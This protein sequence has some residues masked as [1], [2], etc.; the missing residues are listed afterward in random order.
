MDADDLGRGPHRADPRRQ[1]RAEPAAA[2][3]RGYRAGAASLAD[4]PADATAFG[5][6]DANFSVVAFG[7]DRARLDQ[8]WQDMYRHV[9]GLYLSFE[10]DTR[11]ERLSD[12]FPAATLQ[13]LRALKHRYDPD[14]VFRDNFNIA[15]AP[16]L[17]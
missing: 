10:T 4:V 7:T 2:T 8:A 13:R 6:R 14:N 1:Q 16:G 11:P 17:S 15:P 9:R 3:A 5:T 12:A